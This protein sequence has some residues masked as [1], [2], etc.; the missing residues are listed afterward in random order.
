MVQNGGDLFGSLFNVCRLGIKVWPALNIRGHRRRRE[1][2]Q[3]HCVFCVCVCVGNR[4]QRL[5]Y[6]EKCELSLKPVLTLVWNCDT[7]GSNQSSQVP[8]LIMS[9]KALRFYQWNCWFLDDVV[10]GAEC[11]TCLPCALSDRVSHEH[12][13]S[14]NLFQNEK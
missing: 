10:T 3:C 13:I 1:V 11:V 14:S 5:I 9:L 7:N 2:W 4:E 8:H 12:D 6:V